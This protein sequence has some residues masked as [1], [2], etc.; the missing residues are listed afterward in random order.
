[1]TGDR[2]AAIDRHGLASLIDHS[3][4]RP[5]ATASDLGALC[6]EA[7]EFGV[8]AVCVSPSLLPV[9]VGSLAPGIAVA[10]VAGFPSGAHTG[11][12]KAGEAGAAVESGATEIDMVINLGAALSGDWP[13][14][15][16]EVSRIRESVGPSTLLK[17]IVESAIL[18]DD[19]LVTA[20]RVAEAGGADFVKTSTGFHPAGGATVHAVRLMALA[21]APRLGV[22]AA[23]GIRTASEAISMVE[24]GANRLGTSRT[25]EILAELPAR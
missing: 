4:L 18:D 9:P 6:A 5:E 12:V 10:A 17:V 1:M 22:K 2:F 24:A 11:A 7:S 8:A 23:G 19:Q 20:C 21:V 3:L 15:E 25:A 14:V 16:A 13:V